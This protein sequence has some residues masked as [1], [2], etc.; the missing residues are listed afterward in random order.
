MELLIHDG[1][2]INVNKKD[3][4]HIIVTIDYIYILLLWNG[5]YSCEFLTDCSYFIK[6]IHIHDDIRRY[7]LWDMGIYW[8]CDTKCTSIEDSLSAK[9][10]SLWKINSLI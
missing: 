3:P 9:I 1:N 4:K 5:G 10:A 7:M 6:N 8:C 2:A